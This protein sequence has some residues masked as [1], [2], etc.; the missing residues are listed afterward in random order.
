MQ[1]NQRMQAYAGISKNVDFIEGVTPEGVV[2]VRLGLICTV[3]FRQGGQRETGYKVLGCFD[4]FV[5]QFGEHLQGQFHDFSGRGFTSLR[6]DSIAKAKEKLSGSVDEGLA[7][8]WVLQ[9]EKNG[10]V[11]AEYFI[12][13]LTFNAESDPYGAM[14]C[15]KIMLPWQL[16][17]DADG[18]QKFREWAR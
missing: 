16:L 12:S 5:E 4:R 18:E 15:V 10:E 13:A 11:A 2:L 1:E 17:A 9:S 7:V 14:S 6:K 8:F 3:Y